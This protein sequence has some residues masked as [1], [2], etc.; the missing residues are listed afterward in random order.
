YRHDFARTWRRLDRF[1]DGPPLLD[2]L[3][4]PTGRR[5]VFYR[6]LTGEADSAS[7]LDPFQNQDDLLLRSN[8]RRFVSQGVQSRVRIDFRTGEVG[9][10]LEVGARFHDDSI[11]RDH[12]RLAYRMQNRHLVRTSEAAAL[13]TSNRGHATAF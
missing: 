12:L 3:A 8:G 10:D 9:H 7:V 5:E 13:D 11:D 4:D 2:V 6:V 1:R